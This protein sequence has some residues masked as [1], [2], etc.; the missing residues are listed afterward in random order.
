[1]G[2]VAADRFAVLERARQAQLR[3]L[4]GRRT[5]QNGGRFG[6]ASAGGPL[7]NTYEQVS[8]AKSRSLP[9]GD[10]AKPLPRAPYRPPVVLPRYVQR[11][12]CDALYTW[13]K[14]DPSRVARRPLLCGSWRHAGACARY[15]ASVAFARM[16]EAFDKLDATG[17]VFMVLTLDQNGVY[18]ERRWR[19]VD[20]ANAS[21]SQQSRNFLKRLRRYA[22]QRGWRDFGSQWVATV[23]SHRTGWPHMN[24]V[25][26]C[27]ELAHELAASYD[28]RRAQGASHR[29]ASLLEGDLL[30]I[31]MG[32]GWGAQSVAERG[33]DSNALASYIAKL[34]GKADA[35][36]GELAKLSQSPT[37][38]RKGFRRLRAGVGFLPKQRRNE[39]YT[40]TLI[41]RLPDARRTAYAA[42]PLVEVKDPVA[43]ALAP[44]LCEA[45]EG[46]MQ[47]EWSYRQPLR[48]NEERPPLPTR[49]MYELRDGRF[50]LVA[51]AAPLGDGEVPAL[52]AQS[53]PDR[54]WFVLT[55]DARPPPD[56]SAPHPEKVQRVEQV[57]LELIDTKPVFELRRA[58]SHVDTE[59]APAEL[60][61]S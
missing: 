6:A 20:E 21:L 37:A 23:E 43:R 12:G 45:E 61:R 1:M 47:R 25:I 57:Q 36:A 8:A 30:D 28:R 3:T 4:A 34:A 41:R 51:G 19:D 40:G 35:T 48:M 15:S 32:T 26:H 58:H 55:P 7:G 54:T 2:S 29:S 22:K 46:V 42:I 39:A 9:V 14:R 13:E 53:N 24:F 33:R 56:A 50:V 52:G 17:N 5:G 60:K 16:K 44:L 38:A 59:R 10:R 49:T 31:A 11:C 27:P 18:S